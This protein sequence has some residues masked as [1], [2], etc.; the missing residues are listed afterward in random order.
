MQGS[1]EK[2]A[3]EQDSRH[4]IGVGNSWSEN[5]L[6][7][8]STKRRTFQH[9]RVQR[10]WTFHLPIDVPS[11]IPRS[12][13]GS[14]FNGIRGLNGCMFTFFTVT[15]QPPLNKEKRTFSNQER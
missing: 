4:M 7:I 6:L 1:R 2:T 9:Q 14:V 13:G 8:E 10:M 12:V 5:F 15:F 3:I 11:D